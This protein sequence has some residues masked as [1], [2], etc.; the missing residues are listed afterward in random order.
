MV[1][2][3]VRFSHHDVAA[4]I[5]SHRQIVADS[6]REWRDC[7][8]RA[9]VM[10]WTTVIDSRG[11]ARLEARWVDQAVDTYQDPPIDTPCSSFALSAA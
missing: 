7:G 2:R 6:V 3:V 8:G 5:V 9:L 10:R 1:F 4:P 11:V